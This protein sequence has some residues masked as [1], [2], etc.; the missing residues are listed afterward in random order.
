MQRQAEKK[1]KKNVKGGSQCWSV[2]VGGKAENR[3]L[4]FDLACAPLFG[5]RLETK[6]NLQPT[7]F[8]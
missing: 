8:P 4:I 3:F 6:C 7:L 1:K 2:A 5:T